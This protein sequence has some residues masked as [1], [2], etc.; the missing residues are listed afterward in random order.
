MWSCNHKTYEMMCHNSVLC[1]IN[2]ELVNTFIVEIR[3]DISY[4]S[5]HIDPTQFSKEDVSCIWIKKVYLFS[6]EGKSF[7]SMEQ[8]PSWEADNQSAS[9]EIPCHLWNLKVWCSKSWIQGHSDSLHSFL[10]AFHSNKLRASRMWNMYHACASGCSR[11]YVELYVSVPPV[12][13]INY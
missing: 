2:I 8:R 5:F 11:F 1:D 12:I 4:Y 13:M 9:K 3:D 7:C 6:R 10:Y